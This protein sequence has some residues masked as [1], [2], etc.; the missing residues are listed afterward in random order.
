MFDYIFHFNGRQIEIV[1]DTI[2][3]ALEYLQFREPGLLFT[4]LSYFVSMKTGEKTPVFNKR[5]IFLDKLQ[6]LIKV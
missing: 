2:D 3:E 6:E 5:E 1:A 4:H